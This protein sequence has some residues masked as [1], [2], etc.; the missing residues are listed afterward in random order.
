MPSPTEQRA[1]SRARWTTLIPAT[2]A[3]LVAAVLVHF[4]SRQLDYL[5][6]SLEAKALSFAS[7]LSESV[8][9]SVAFADVETA[10]EAFAIAAQDQDVTY[11]AVLYEDGAVLH[12][13]GSTQLPRAAAEEGL[14]ATEDVLRVI[15]P[16]QSLE[17]PRGTV[18]VEVSR[19]G[20]L[21]ESRSVMLSAAITGSIALGLALLVAWFMRSLRLSL[22]RVAQAKADLVVA[23]R[24][25]REHLEAKQRET[26]RFLEQMPVAVHVLDADGALVFSNRESIRIMGES[27]A[28]E[29]RLRDGDRL[30]ESEELPL[31]QALRGNAIST[32]AL[33]IVQGQ[34]RTPISAIATPISDDDGNI[35][36]GLLAFRDISEKL[37]AEA[38]RLQS[39]KLESVGQ[40]AAGI[41]HEINTPMQYIGDNT[42]F[43]KKVMPKLWTMLDYQT[44]VIESLGDDAVRAQQVKKAKRCK[45]QYI[46]DRLPKAVESAI[47]GV[48][49]VSR[50]VQS[51]KEFSHPGTE[52]KVPTDINKALATTTTVSRNEWKYIAEL[53]TDLATDL[54]LVPALGGELN[55]VFL[56]LVV[57]ASHAIAD[58]VEPG[59]QGTIRVATRLVDEHVEISIADS[60]VGIPEQIRNRIFDPFF[61]TKEVGKGTGQGLAIARSIVVDKHGGTLSVESEIGKGTTFF[62]RLPVTEPDADLAAA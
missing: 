29:Y 47:E 45:V 33:D 53:E 11:L 16:L 10:R 20:L 13:L 23:Q 32:D 51:M 4:S 44:E 43:V 14:T 1:V 17:G 48:E 41:A 49:A 42:G 9:S 62:I 21:A 52:H 6:R 25:E 19:Q 60:G 55:Q 27:D 8:K 31:V 24:L 56:N 40:L 46:R 30:C 2:L 57:N 28:F 37:R 7:M 59:E 58:A 39:Q 36:F 22:Q 34:R 3:V 38:E 35:S 50:L 5:E 15:R 26:F 12:E 18:I 61:T 54:P